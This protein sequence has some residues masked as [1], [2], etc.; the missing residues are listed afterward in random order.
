[1]RYISVVGFWMVML[2][3]LLKAEPTASIPNSTTIDSEQ[4]Q[5]ITA[6]EQTV[7]YFEGKVKLTSTG[8]KGTCDRMEITMP[9]NEG[10]KGVGEMGSVTYILAL[11]NVEMI[12]VD[13]RATAGRADIY[14]P[15]GKIVF[16]ENPVVYENDNIIKGERITLFRDQGKMIVEGG[17]SGSSRPS[18]IL[19]GIHK[20][21]EP[22]VLN[23]TIKE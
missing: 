8:L 14:P 16:T 6:P 10:G 18:I 19:P 11:G 9:E 20:P 17:E 13:R 4:V 15:E 12:Q 1:M 3:S 2:I 7:F 23:E 22:Q 21:V 5:V